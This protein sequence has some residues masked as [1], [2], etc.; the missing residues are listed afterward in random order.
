MKDPIER[1]PF[2]G[3]VTGIGQINHDGTDTIYC[4]KCTV[5][6]AKTIFDSFEVQ[7]I[8]DMIAKWNRRATQ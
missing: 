1:C 7:T 8:G 3:G 4:M 6:E 5:C 2:C